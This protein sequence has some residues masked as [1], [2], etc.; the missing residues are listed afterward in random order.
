M[1]AA[2]AAEKEVAKR[3][4]QRQDPYLKETRGAPPGSPS[5]GVDAA[6]SARAVDRSGAPS[7]IRNYA[8]LVRA[9]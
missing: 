7:G 5:D 9:D 6:I 1:P 4:S 8:P 3:R 2:S